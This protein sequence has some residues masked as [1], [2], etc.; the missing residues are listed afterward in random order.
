MHRLRPLR[1][2]LPPRR[3]RARGRPGGRRTGGRRAGG[4]RT[5]GQQG[6]GQQGGGRRAR[7]LHGMRRMRAELPGLR[8]HGSGRRRLRRGHHRL[9]DRKAG[10]LRLRE[11]DEL[12]L[13]R[14]IITDMS[15][16]SAGRK[17]PSAK[18][19]DEIILRIISDQ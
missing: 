14:G 17:S 12:L 4:R 3:L 11:R 5:G 7:A 9:A 2:S 15:T 6:G 8:D 18:K 19:Y 16:P 13:K 10:S 1:R